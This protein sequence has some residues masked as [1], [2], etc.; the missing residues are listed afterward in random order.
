M[1]GGVKSFTDLLAWQKCHTLVKMA[2]DFFEKS[3]RSNVLKNQI[4]LSQDIGYI[5]HDQYDKLIS[6][7]TAG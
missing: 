1:A 5:S 4:I 7:S 3:Y 2:Y 6:L